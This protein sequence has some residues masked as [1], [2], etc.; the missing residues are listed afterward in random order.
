MYSQFN[1]YVFA[2]YSGVKDEADSICPQKSYNP[3]FPKFQ[4]STIVILTI[5][6][7]VNLQIN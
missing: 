7:Y 4:Y 3:A 1:M 2:V 6:F 5:F